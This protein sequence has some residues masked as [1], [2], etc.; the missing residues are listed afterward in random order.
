MDKVRK[1]SNSVCY[2]TLFSNCNSLFLTTWL[3]TR[4][5]TFQLKKEQNQFRKIVCSVR[6]I[7]RKPKS[8]N[9]L[10]LSIIY[11]CQNLLKVKYR[12]EFSHNYGLLSLCAILIC[13]EN[14]WKGLNREC[15][16]M[17]HTMAYVYCSATKETVCFWSKCKG[18]LNN[19][20]PRNE[21]FR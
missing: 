11:H 8:R 7:W 9:P 6:N 12:E 16:S 1:P 19:D 21:G 10:I 15:D 3:D 20:V 13:I 14:Y 2:L 18:N 4:L 17:S 5:S